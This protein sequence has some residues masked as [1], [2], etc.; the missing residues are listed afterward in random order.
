MRYALVEEVK[1]VRRMAA[2]VCAPGSADGAYFAL[3][4]LVT[5][6]SKTSGGPINGLHGYG[7]QNTPGE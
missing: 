6:L 5:N 1:Y 4:G 7:V 3:F 2:C